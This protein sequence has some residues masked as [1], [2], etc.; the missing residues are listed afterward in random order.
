M[1]LEFTPHVGDVIGDILDA[2]APAL[3][4]VSTFRFEF[5]FGL[6]NSGNL[7]VQQCF[8][9]VDVGEVALD[10][11]PVSFECGDHGTV[12]GCL[13]ITID[14]ANTLGEHRVDAS[15]PFAE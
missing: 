7:I 2:V 8:A 3:V 14:A 13:T 9:S 15:E 1:C 5:C 12:D 4:E 10:L 6:S 11:F